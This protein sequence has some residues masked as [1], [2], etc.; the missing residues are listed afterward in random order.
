MR[1]CLFV[2]SDDVSK[3]INLYNEIILKIVENLGSFTIINFNNILKKSQNTIYDQNNAYVLRNKFG[4]R[5]NY[6]NPSKKKEFFEYIGRDKIFAI[7]CLGKSFKFFLIRRLINKENIK[8]I[9]IMNL[10]FVS[11]ELPYS[12]NSSKGYLFKFK[13]T[14]N[15]LIY[16]LLVIIKFFPNIFIYFESRKEIYQSCVKNKKKK[17]SFFFP[18]L[19]ILYFENIYQINSL[20]HEHYLKNKNSLEEKK[21]IFLDGNY[22]HLDIINRENLDLIKL[23][24]EYFKKLEIFF[25]QIQSVY[26]QTL[27]ICLH[28]SSDKREYEDFFRNRLITQNKTYESLVKASVVIFHESSIV[29]D[30]IIYNKKIISLSTD[31]FGK[32]MS[33]RINYYKNK[34]NLI[35][36]NLD[37]LEYNN[38]DNIIK[39]LAEEL[40]HRNEGIFNL[41]D[42]ELGSDKVIMILKQYI[43]V[44]ELV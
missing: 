36:I 25:N 3:E 38:V 2:A 33:N 27:E 19:N 30:A 18:F 8:L 40:K 11:N 34:Y 37:N 1:V 31:L 22:R 28:P 41:K 4:D 32:Y 14:I 39:D 35:S 15:N 24:K 26:N 29:L 21:I 13:R 5:V 9:L 6:F 42:E 10:G 43:K 7:D 20:S 17:L 12:I 23:K 16:K 44:Q